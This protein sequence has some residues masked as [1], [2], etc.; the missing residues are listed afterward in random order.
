MA[1]PV[2]EIFFAGN[3]LK[4]LKITGPHNLS[5]LKQKKTQTGAAYVHSTVCC[6]HHYIFA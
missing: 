2:Y 3:I 6:K 1:L 5:N 4:E